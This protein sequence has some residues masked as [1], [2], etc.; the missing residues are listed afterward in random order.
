[1]AETVVP[2]EYSA[3]VGVIVPMSRFVNVCGVETVVETKKDGM[4]T[5]I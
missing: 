1:V 5:S 3:P 2:R 4:M